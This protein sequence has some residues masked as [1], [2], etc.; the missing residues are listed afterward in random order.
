MTNEEIIQG[1]LA[2]VDD[3]IDPA[4]LTRVVDHI[5]SLE[6]KDLMDTIVAM[7]DGAVAAGEP[8]KLSIVRLNL[9]MAKHKTFTD[10]VLR[11]H[12]WRNAQ[13]QKTTERNVIQGR[14][15]DA[16]GRYNATLA[17]VTKTEH[18]QFIGDM[19]RAGFVVVLLVATEHGNVIP[20]VEITTAIT[21]DVVRAKTSIIALIRHGNLIHPEWNPA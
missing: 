6:S 20:A 4:Y 7:R 11:L 15:N 2:I 1:M 9:A 3:N 14:S 16:S 17:K 8:G 12:A 10:A 21:E 5:A 18:L 13:P 19:N